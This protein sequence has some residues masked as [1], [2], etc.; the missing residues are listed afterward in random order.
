[1][2]IG[3]DKIKE[4]RDMTGVSVMK[5]KE[6]LMATSGD[7]K[8]AILELRKQGEKDIAKKSQRTAKEGAVVSYVHSNGKIGSMLKLYCETDFV[9][10]N[11]EFKELA[12]DIAMQIAATDPKFLDSA[13]IP[14]D[15]LES[16]RK[17]EQEALEKDSKPKNIK[18]KII[19]GKLKK[20]AQQNSLLSQDFIKNPEI[21]IN[22]LVKEKI[23]KLGENIKVGEFIRF[24]L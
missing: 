24:E 21:T 9:A 19:E 8:K 13:N 5:C 16:E 6:A 10:K 4:L 12:K 11:D 2:E 18:N 3:A 17:I 14:K 1:M 20:F 15:L 23:N 22:D 7:L